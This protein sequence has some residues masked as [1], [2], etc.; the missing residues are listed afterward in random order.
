[1]H[2]ALTALVSNNSGPDLDAL[3][4]FWAAYVSG[5]NAIFPALDTAITAIADG[6][7][8]YGQIIDEFQTQLDEAIV[9]AAAEAGLGGLIDIAFDALTDGVGALLSGPAGAAIASAA[10]QFVTRVCEAVLSALMSA[11]QI[12]NI[13]VAAGSDLEPAIQ[14]IPQPSTAQHEA[15]ETGDAIQPDPN[16]TGVPRGK[17]NPAETSIA[18]Y[19]QGRGHVVIP[20]H[21]TS[22]QGRTPD[23]LV[24]GNPVE[25]K[26]L[27]GVQLRKIL[28][29]SDL[30][31]GQADEIFIRATSPNLTAQAAE[32]ELQAYYHAN[33]THQ[34]QGNI[35]RVTV[36][37]A[38]GT[39]VTYPP[40]YGG[41]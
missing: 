37:L 24:D 7:T 4:E 11:S 12:H 16:P 39:R 29:R 32:R 40:G 8:T 13:G 19:L 30:D 14:H 6:L 9:E 1:M 20:I 2:T 28:Y 15:W 23:S 34:T 31:G 41:L 38:D 3:N 17:F 18:E 26:T 33:G 5:A 22:G 21:D 35:Q 27:N 25:F 36:L 10:E